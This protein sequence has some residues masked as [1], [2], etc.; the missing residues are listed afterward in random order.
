MAWCHQAPS[1]YLNQCWPRSMTPYDV[2][3]PQWVKLLKFHGKLN[4]PHMMYI[5]SF[6]IMNTHSNLKHVW[7]DV[8]SPLLVVMNWHWT[9]WWPLFESAHTHTHA[10]TDTETDTETDTDRQTD[11]TRAHHFKV[12]MAIQILWKFRFALMSILTKWLLNFFT[13]NM[14]AVALINA[15]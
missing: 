8:A 7:L 10:L 4:W 15:R 3:R 5:I 11:K 9:Q 2:T 6:E 12:S 1:H 14:T 13:H